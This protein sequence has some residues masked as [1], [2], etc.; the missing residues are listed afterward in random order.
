MDKGFVQPSPQSVVSFLESSV[1][2][3]NRKSRRS[4]KTRT[5][6]F[7]HRDRQIERSRT[8]DIVNLG[9]VPCSR[10]VSAPRCCRRWT[11]VTDEYDSFRAAPSLEELG[12]DLPNGLHRWIR[13]S[14]HEL[15]VHRFVP[16]IALSTRCAA[17]SAKLVELVFA[18]ASELP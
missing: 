4:R 6:L 18:I 2:S 17:P 12:F 7:E 11:S 10:G 16:R 1:F 3:W 9:E 15:V 5:I 13:N 8:A 14:G